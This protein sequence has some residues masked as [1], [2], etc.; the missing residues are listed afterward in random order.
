MGNATKVAR[1][2]LTS[3]NVPAHTTCACTHECSNLHMHKL[4]NLYLF[5]EAQK[6]AE[7]VTRSCASPGYA[8]YATHGW[9]K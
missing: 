7:C 4:P 1:C 6:R 2:T 3:I 9:R 5:R 8:T